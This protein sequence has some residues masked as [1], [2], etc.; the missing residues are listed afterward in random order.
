MGLA[1][2]GQ[3]HELGENVGVQSAQ[4]LGERATQLTLRVFHTG[5]ATDVGSGSKVLGSFN[6]FQQLTKLP[7]QIPNSATLSSRS[8]TVEKVE[9]DPTG[10]KVWIGGKSHHV[11]RDPSGRPLH[12]S[13]TGISMDP[14]RKP[15]SPPRPGLKVERGQPLSDPNRTLVNPHDLY[16]ATGNIEA[17][18]GFLTDEMHE[19]YK[20]EGIKKVQV[21]TLVKAMSNL[22][23]VRE[24]GDESGVL[25]GEFHPTSRISALNRKLIREGKKPIEHE[26][27]LKGIDMLPLSMQDDWMAKLQH[28]RLEQTILDAAS[29]YG[30][31]NIHGT[32]PIPGMAVGSEFGMTQE[33]IKGKPSLKHLEDVPVFNY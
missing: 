26:P 18:Q 31:S 1:S 3:L 13:L 9:K 15:W 2:K 20:N 6:R 28:E 30:K 17:V 11:G 19:I 23:K 10:V 25:R 12:Q 7:K 21:E 16:K 4:S 5:G 33:D 32:H 24:E 14:S 29:T 27:V 8:G 22:T